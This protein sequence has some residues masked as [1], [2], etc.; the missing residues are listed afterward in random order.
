MWPAPSPGEENRTPER[1]PAPPTARPVPGIVSTVHG[2]REQRNPDMPEL[3]R[4]RL[5]T[6][7]ALTSAL[8]LVAGAVPAAARPTTRGVVLPAPT[9]PECLGTVSL[10]LIDTTRIDPWAPSRRAREIM[11]QIW[12]PARN[13]R[14]HAA[15]PWLSPGAVPHFA[16]VFGF[17]ADIIRATTTHA[18]AGA[19]A[20]RERGG[21]PVVLYSPGLGGGRGTGTALVE[22]LASHGYVVVT[23]DHTYDASEVE[24]PG[25]RVEVS[26]IPPEIDDQV[27]AQAVAVREADTRFVLDRLAALAA[28]KRPFGELDLDR[29][30][31]F[32]HSLGGSTAAATMHG[33]RRL[34][35]GVNMDGTLVGAA[36][37]AG[38]D[39]PFLLLSSDHGTDPE[40]PTWDTFW[41]NQRGWK[42][43][44]RLSGS[45]HASFNDSE[46]FLPQLAAAL[47]LTPDQVA[48]Q[49]GTLDPHRSVAIQRTYLRAFFDKHL[50]RRDSHLFR[51]PDRRYPE[52]TFTR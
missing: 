16:E 49:I 2:N 4:R 37:V 3:T 26:A 46:V 18:R 7:A 1:L 25:G 43:E 33:D 31:M 52:M 45:T 15:A 50:R 47:G 39:R 11:V 36:A 19:P 30:G 40:D 29:V 32:G 6:A 28:G 51:G 24:F 41:A 44:L 34:K 17:P 22:D 12:Y 20:D 38:S 48:E 8:G 10:H 9:G 23:I 5:L 13:T 42:R 21:R 27:I 14:G 35:A